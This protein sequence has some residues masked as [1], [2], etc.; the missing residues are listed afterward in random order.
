MIRWVLD[1]EYPEVNVSSSEIPSSLPFSL[2][3]TP[4]KS[5]VNTSTYLRKIHA[6][7]NLQAPEAFG[8]G[9][10]SLRRECRKKEW[11]KVDLSGKLLTYK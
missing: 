2:P 7:L 9:Y 11:M 10:T 5:Q 1:W 4:T 6:M 8:E 3:K